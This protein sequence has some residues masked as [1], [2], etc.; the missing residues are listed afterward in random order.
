MNRKV[1][2]CL[3]LLI[4]CAL[5]LPGQTSA[6]G[7]YEPYEYK[8]SNSG[9]GYLREVLTFPDYLGGV[10]VNQKGFMYQ[11]STASPELLSINFDEDMRMRLAMRSSRRFGFSFGDGVARTAFDY[12][13]KDTFKFYTV[14]LDFYTL[15]VAPEFTYAYGGSNAVTFQFGIDFLNIGFSAGMLDRGTIE[16]N[17]IAQVNLLTFAMRPALFFDFGR[18]GIGIAFM[19]NPYNFIEYDYASRDY[20]SKDDVGLKFASSRL[21]KYSVEILFVL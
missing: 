21:R 2:C 19:F 20:F 11:H 16:K 4:L 15:G 3:A 17:F 7:N 12:F 10:E 14:T 9:I 6:F 8:V 5:P 1:W 13:R 18:R